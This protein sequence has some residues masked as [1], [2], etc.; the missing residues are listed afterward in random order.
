VRGSKEPSR[1]H[2]ASG[3]QKAPVA[4]NYR[5]CAHALQL[6]ASPKAFTQVEVTFE[7]TDGSLQT[8]ASNKEQLFYREAVSKD[9]SPGKQGNGGCKNTLDDAITHKA[10]S[11]V[12]HTCCEWLSTGFLKVCQFCRLSQLELIHSFIHSYY[13]CSEKSREDPPALSGHRRG[14]TF[15]SEVVK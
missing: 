6:V 4:N 7:R 9:K 3:A 14:S 2:R 8:V 12:H 1:P 5:L 11:Y 10:S 15:S 13:T